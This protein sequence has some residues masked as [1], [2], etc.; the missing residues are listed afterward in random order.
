MKLR[1][2][3]P[4]HALDVKLGAEAM[5]HSSPVDQVENEDAMPRPTCKTGSRG[6]D[7]SLSQII[8]TK[9]MSCVVLR[10]KASLA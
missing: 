4:C 2:R 3:M 8:E 6:Q 5:T 7:A 10:S 1:V 9:C